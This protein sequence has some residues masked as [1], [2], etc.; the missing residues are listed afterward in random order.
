M[1]PL[2]AF[3]GQSKHWKTF[4]NQIN[5]FIQANSAALTTDK[6]KNRLVMSYLK[7]GSALEYTQL[8]LQNVPANV[9][10]KFHM[11]FMAA[12]DNVFGDP[13]KKARVMTKLD[14]MQQGNQSLGEFTMDFE[15]TYMLAGYDTM[16]H[17]EQLCH[18]Y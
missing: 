9:Q 13:S 10:Q 1:P 7:E 4:K 12:M 16:T 5:T 18:K 15:V 14:K 17:C 8:S 11:A 3:D 2:D 6:D